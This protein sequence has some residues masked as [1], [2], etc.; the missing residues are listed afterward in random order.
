MPTLTMPRSIGESCEDSL[1]S[2][3]NVQLVCPF[4]YLVIGRLAVQICV[5]VK[6]IF[7]NMN[8]ES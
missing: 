6:G 8:H 1:E 2:L 3:N 7:A 5:Q 4:L